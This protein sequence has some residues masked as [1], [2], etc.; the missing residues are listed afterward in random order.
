MVP[1]ISKVVY[2]VLGRI[3]H[4]ITVRAISTL[5]PQRTAS[6]SRETLTYP[7]TQWSKYVPPA[8]AGMCLTSAI[9]ILSLLRDFSHS[10]TPH[11]LRVSRVWKQINKWWGPLVHMYLNGRWRRESGREV[12]GTV[13]K[14]FSRPAEPPDLNHECIQPD[15]HSAK[16]DLPSNLATRLATDSAGQNFPWPAAM[17]SKRDPALSHVF[18]AYILESKNKEFSSQK[19]ILFKFFGYC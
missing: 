15:P 8:R 1:V 19:S 7:G 17:V 6:D 2:I 11:S 18:D 12:L 14:T 13:H 10:S 16:T 5:L 3:G 4:K 9:A